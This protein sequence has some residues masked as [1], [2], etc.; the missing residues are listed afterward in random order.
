MDDSSTPQNEWQTC[1]TGQIDDMLS[2]VRRR[3][4]NQFLVRAGS[5]AGVLLLAGLSPLLLSSASDV[6]APEPV[7]IADAEVGSKDSSELCG[8]TCQE[9]KKAARKW[10]AG[11]LPE[12]ESNEIEAHLKECPHCPKFVNELRLEDDQSL[13]V[14]PPLRLIASH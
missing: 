5:V 9:L 2:L 11:E 4:R 3:R 1:P 7:P 10:L 12:A 6:P 14:A 8:I 13:L